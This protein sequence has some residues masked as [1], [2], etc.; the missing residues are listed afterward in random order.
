ME[1]DDAAA[2]AD[3]CGLFCCPHT[4]VALAAMEKLIDRGEIRK[5]DRVVVISTAHGLKFVDFKIRY[6]R[7]EIEDV[8][9][10]YANSPIELPAR[11][12]AVRDRMLREIE[13]RL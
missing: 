3:L 12:D 8:A 13:R 10:G 2:R 5:G 4:G 11:Y 7:D 6:H 9:A 1:L